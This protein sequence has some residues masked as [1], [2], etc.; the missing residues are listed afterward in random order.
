MK[1]FDVSGCT[2]SPLP[3]CNF[4]EL[5]N[6]CINTQN[7]KQVRFETEETPP[8]HPI[9]NSQANAEVHETTVAPASIP[10]E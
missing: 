9:K 8:Q 4:H 5:D 7:T 6:M 1:A 2:V 10:K 3:P